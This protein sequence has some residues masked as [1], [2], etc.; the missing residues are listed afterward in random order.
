[1]PISQVLSARLADIPEPGS[2]MTL[3]ACAPGDSRMLAAVPRNVSSCNMFLQIGMFHIH[4]GFLLDGGVGRIGFSTPRQPHHHQNPR[5]I[6]LGMD[7]KFHCS[8][9][10]AKGAIMENRTQPVSRSCPHCGVAA[11][12]M[13]KVAHCEVY[14]CPHC[15]HYRIS[16][17]N[18]KLIAK[19]V[20]DPKAFQIHQH[21]DGNRWLQSP[22]QTAKVVT[23]LEEFRRDYPEISNRPDGEAGAMAESADPESVLIAIE[24]RHRSP[25]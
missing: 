2:T 19:R 17:I 25:L 8:K 15:G 12:L 16:E 1:M 6:H 7:Q 5:H 24:R 3:V 22:H 23:L 18:Q 13:P 4:Y 21:K 20:V 11:K 10:N 14:V 9:V